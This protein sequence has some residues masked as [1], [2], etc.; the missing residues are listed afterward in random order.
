MR[1][2]GMRFVGALSLAGM[3]GFVGISTVLAHEGRHVEGFRFT[4]GFL[5]EPAYEGLVNGV[6][7]EVMVE[8]G[9]HADVDDMASSKGMS[10]HATHG[11]IFVSS[12]LANGDA[13]DAVIPQGFHETT[14]PFHSHLNE[15]I[16]GSIEIAHDAPEADRVGVEL[17]ADRAQ[18][19]ELRVR[20]GT[21]LVFTNRS[22]EP[23]IIASGIHD[24][25]G[26][27]DAHEHVDGEAS[28]GHGHASSHQP[29]TGLEGSLEVE[30][31]H[32][33]SAQ[34]VVMSLSPLVDHAGAYSAPFIP[35]QE[36]AYRFRF[37]GTIEGLSINEVFE[38]GEHTFDAVQAQA[39]AQFPIQVASTREL[40]G[41]VR[42]SQTTAEDASASVAGARAIS[43]GALITG[44]I[45]LVTAVG[46][47][48]FMFR[49]RSGT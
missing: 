41:V 37:V 39:A 10:D 38:S 21:T 47:I 15:A 17:L 46:A 30:V 13:F 9:E 31:T 34:S 19:N 27:S 35:T 36:G 22:G 25:A 40:E 16:A 2:A 33:A 11:Q 4:V 1:W 20:P 8:G 7:L 42:M 18:P 48:G 45:G 3:L 6:F 44:V 24:Q 14:I 28:E 49:T 5:D 26:E 43:I 32:I 29:V 23:Q 12:Q